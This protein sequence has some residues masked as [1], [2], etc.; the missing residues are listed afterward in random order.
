MPARLCLRHTAHP[1]DVRFA[2]V[3]FADVR[4]ADVRTADVRTADVRFA[5]VRTARLYSLGAL[6]LRSFN[7][8]I[9]CGNTPRSPAAF[10]GG[11][12]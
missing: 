2:D 8:A 9:A 3:R 11:D 5:D 10:F 7:E 1:A 6:P 4:F 12:G